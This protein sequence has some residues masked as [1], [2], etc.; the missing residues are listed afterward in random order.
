MFLQSKSNLGGHTLILGRQWL[1]TVDDFIS[2]ILGHMISSY[3]DSI[4]KYNLYQPTK[5]LTKS[6]FTQCFQDAN[7]DLLVILYVLA[8]ENC[9]N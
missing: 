9:T 5:E 6:K 3:G 7:N 8:E 4:N 2:C 1:A